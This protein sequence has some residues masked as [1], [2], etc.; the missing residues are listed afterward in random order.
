VDSARSG[1]SAALA[2]AALAFAA[3]AVSLYWTLGGTGLLD[4][5]GGE[6]ERLARER[7]A[8]A[9]AVIAATAV[10]KL[11]A[12][13]LALALPRS[14]RRPLFLVA[15]GGGALLALYGAVLVVAG[16]LVLAGA[17]DPSDPVDEYALRWHVF[18]WDMWF[19]LWG[20]ALALAGVLARR[21]QAATDAS[22]STARS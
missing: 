7:S 19:V 8:P 21:R 17:I 18:V 4:A 9:V 11:L 16:A 6:I 22:A 2:A 3:A 20:V 10:A 1:R 12:G 13:A 14:D 15:I 5:V